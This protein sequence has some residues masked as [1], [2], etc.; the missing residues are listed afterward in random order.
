[1]NRRS[2]IKTAAALSV[3]AEEFVAAAEPGFDPVEQSIGSLQRALARV[4]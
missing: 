2:F 4:R 1:M 3:T